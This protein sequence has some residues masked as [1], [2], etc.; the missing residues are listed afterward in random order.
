MMSHRCIGGIRVAGVDRGDDRFVLGDQVQHRGAVLQRQMAD[1][2]HVALDVDHGA[3]GKLGVGAGI[4]SILYV[5]ATGWVVDHFSYNPI[6]IIASLLPILGTVIL[7]ILGG[8]IEKI[9][10][11]NAT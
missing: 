11:T 2:V 9:R 3:P 5:L 10:I 6:L 8:R 4:G 7:F 1:A